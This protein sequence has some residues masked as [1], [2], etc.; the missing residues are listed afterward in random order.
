MTN[1]ALKIDAQI[2]EDCA[3]YYADPL[4]FVYWAFPWGEG[5]LEG[6]DGPD[7][8]QIEFLTNLGEAVRQRGFNGIDP[9]A[10]IN[11]S[12]ASGHGIGKSALSAM[13]TL[14]IMSTR[15]HSKGV[16]TANTSDQLKTKTWGELAKWKKMCI[17]GHWFDYNN[18]RGNM[19]MYHK[20][21]PQ[22]WRVDAQT[23]KEE[24]SESFAGLHCANSTPWYL[25]DEGSAVPD[26]IYEVAE[27]GKTDGE[28]MHFVFGNPT[29][30]TGRF[31]QIF[32]GDIGKRWNTG[33]IDSRTAK[34]T[35]KVLI[36]Q[37]IDDYGINSD[38]IRVRVLGRFPK[39]GDMQFMPSDIVHLAQTRATPTYFPDDPL[40]SG[41]DCA[42]GGADWNY[43]V[44]RRGFDARS[45]M[46]Y[47][48]PGEASR[49]SMRF[50]S[51]LT[52]IFN[53]HQ[54]DAIFIDSGAMGGPIGDRM[55]QLGFPAYNVGF[56]ESALDQRTYKL[57]NAEMWGKML[58][59]MMAGGAIKNDPELEAQLTNRE[60]WRNAK[61]QII[62]E[63]K[64]D[65]KERGIK[66]PDW[67][68]ALGLTFAMNIPKLTVPKN[69]IMTERGRVKKTGKRNI[70]DR[71]KR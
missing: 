47:R 70:L 64:E 1:T 28:P 66:S 51:K 44:F 59:W 34:M 40:I 53:R 15:P 6:H 3:K 67:G 33:R 21:Y 7:D 58:N 29:R 69:E 8:W 68:D 43:I 2:A 37:W 32:N 10:P 52:D 19:N 9:V 27:G 30:N 60:Y 11:M 31:H 49:D 57:R 17:T 36:Q 45:D 26:K 23:C 38:F 61:E 25:F 39:S 22:T 71:Y 41:V 48:I 24:N 63:P 62:L 54:P 12:R 46:T 42:R 56:G 65:L 35:N 16:V 14:W 13:I 4:G 50:V 5:V 18:S 20:S 55:I